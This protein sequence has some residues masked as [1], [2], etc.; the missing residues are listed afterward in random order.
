MRN[1]RWLTYVKCE[2]CSV[3]SDSL[4]P[5]GLYSPWNSPGQY[6]GVASF[7]FLQ[8]TF[9]TQGLNQSLLHCRQILYQLSHQGSLVCWWVEGHSYTPRSLQEW[10]ICPR[11][12]L[13]SC[14]LLGLSSAESHLPKS[15]P[16]QGTS[17]PR[18]DQCR[19]YHGPA[20]L[21][22]WGSSHLQ[23]SP[24]G[25]QGFHWDHLVAPP[26][27]CLASLSPLPFPSPP[28]P[29]ISFLSLGVDHQRK[30]KRKPLCTILLFV[31]PWTIHTV[32]GILQARILEW[33]ASPFSRG[34][35]RPR[36]QTQVSHIAGGFFTNWATREAQEYWSG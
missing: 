2:S 26:S 15:P 36:D 10:W 32:H 29:P 12:A 20:L 8:G 7:S 23:N 4:W 18:A 34:S 17:H 31:T 35:S 19:G 11:A 22:Q 27:L 21:L 14:P 30:W 5:C 25:L 28:T 9:P 6:T 13:V 16:S 33:V 3:M 24:Q 1:F